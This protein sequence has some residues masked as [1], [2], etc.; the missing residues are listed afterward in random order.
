MTDIK[1]SK[2]EAV[3]L[4][5]ALRRPR[6]MYVGEVTTKLGISIRDAASAFRSLRKYG[7][8]RESKSMLFL[9]QRGRSW[10]MNNQELFMFAGR[11]HWR[12]VP[13]RFRSTSIRP[14]QPYAPRI[15]RLSNTKFVVGVRRAD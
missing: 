2:A 12:E 10:I 5:Q 13:D 8:L 9:T 14:F 15:S 4:A 1:I 6:G 3:L 11:K 7:F